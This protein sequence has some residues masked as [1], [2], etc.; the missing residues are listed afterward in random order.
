L[1]ASTCE[2]LVKAGI[3][4]PGPTSGVNTIARP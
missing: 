3:S 4:L 1:G 2:K